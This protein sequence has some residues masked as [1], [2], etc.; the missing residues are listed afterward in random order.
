MDD[1]IINSSGGGICGTLDASYYKGQGERQGVER[2]YICV[3][4]ERPTISI[5]GNGA[6]PSHKGSGFSENGKMYTLNTIETHAV[7]YVN[8]EE[9]EK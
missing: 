6:R 8:Y 1:R 4:N 5:E 9:K 7:C 3:L 2:E